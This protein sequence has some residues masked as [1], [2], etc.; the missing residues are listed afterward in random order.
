[1]MITPSCRCAV[2]DNDG[3]SAG[4]FFGKGDM[5]ISWELRPSE[6]PADWNR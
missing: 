2:V 4:G 5:L 6:R 3:T 1:M